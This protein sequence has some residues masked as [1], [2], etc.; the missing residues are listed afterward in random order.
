M[1]DSSCL[2]PP[3]TTSFAASGSIV[4]PAPPMPA[5]GRIRLDPRCRSVI[6]VGMMLPSAVLAIL[7]CALLAAPVAGHAQTKVRTETIQVPAGPDAEDTEATAGEDAGPGPAGDLTDVPVPQYD[8]SLLPPPV[9]R[10]RAQIIAA[11]RTGDIEKLRPVI[12][13]NEMPPIFSF[14]G[15]DDAIAYL[16]SIS[17]DPDGRE[18]LA[19]MIEI[20]EAG[21]AHLDPGT[22]QE[23]YVWPYFHAVPFEVLT[24]EQ[25][26]ELYKII[27]PQDRKGMEDYG[28]YTFFRLGIG[29]DGTWHFFVAGD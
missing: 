3:D 11:A 23:M 7:A 29:P 27:T 17:G 1:F 21:Y 14:G 18:I 4:A 9:A 22:P 10:M 28:G 26:V 25:E 12:E 24:P 19:I 20:L 5:G 8:L 13:A 15:E 2:A 16:R 6:M